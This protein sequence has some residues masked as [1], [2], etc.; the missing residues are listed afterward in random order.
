MKGSQVEHVRDPRHYPVQVGD[1]QGEFGRQYLKKRLPTDGG[2]SCRAYLLMSPA[3]GMGELRQS[4]DSLDSK[5]R[6]LP[7]S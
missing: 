1:H 7:K 2:E 4:S 3:A 5:Y 6:A